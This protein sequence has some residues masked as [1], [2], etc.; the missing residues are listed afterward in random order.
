M[1]ITQDDVKEF[2]EIL[3]EADTFK[4]LLQLSVAKALE[5]SSELK[6]LIDAFT[7]YSCENRIDQYQRYKAAG[8]GHESALLL[9]IDAVAARGEALK[10]I[11][12]N[13]N[14]K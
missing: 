11:K 12:L 4:P 8:F 10:S 2:V 3:S 9:T 14:K 1:K 6:P 13:S 7:K 5:F